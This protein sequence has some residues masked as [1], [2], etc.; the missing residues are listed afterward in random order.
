MYTVIYDVAE[1]PLV[2][3]WI[4]FLLI[5]AAVFACMRGTVLRVERKE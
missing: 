2:W 5:I 1:A 3:P 4:T